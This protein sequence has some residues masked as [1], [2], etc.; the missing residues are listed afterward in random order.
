M[1]EGGPGANLASL[2]ESVA[3]LPQCLHHLCFAHSPDLPAFQGLQGSCQASAI[4]KFV[5]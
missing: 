5:L 3:E 4:D 2:T 1:Y